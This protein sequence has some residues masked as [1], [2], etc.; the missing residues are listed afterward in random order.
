MNQ[1]SYETDLLVRQPYVAPALTDYGTVNDL[2]N[3]GNATSGE[4]N[5]QFDKTKRS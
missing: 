3:G 2:T 4:G 5:P 1:S